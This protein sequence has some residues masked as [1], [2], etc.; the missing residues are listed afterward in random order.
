MLI[1]EQVI[2]MVH[3]GTA[4]V[5]E[6]GSLLQLHSLPLQHLDLQLNPL[7]ILNS[8]SIIFILI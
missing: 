6:T 2:T 1:H 4:E 5:G 7:N 8:L 3:L